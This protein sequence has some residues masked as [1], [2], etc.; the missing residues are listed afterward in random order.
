M[1]TTLLTFKRNYRGVINGIDLEYSNGCLEGLNRKIKQIE[2]TAFGC[3]NF[4]N[5]LK[6]IHLEENVVTEKDPYSI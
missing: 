4:V 5:L 6:R 3:R 1:H 2:R